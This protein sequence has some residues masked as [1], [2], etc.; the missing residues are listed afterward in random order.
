MKMGGMQLT[1]T[2][3]AYIHGCKCNA[4][5]EQKGQTCLNHSAEMQLTF[6]HANVM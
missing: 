4:N 1:F 6:A 2:D 3:A 5:R